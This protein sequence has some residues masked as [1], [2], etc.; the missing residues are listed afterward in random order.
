MAERDTNLT[1]RPASIVTIILSVGMQA[2]RY[3]ESRGPPSYERRIRAVIVINL[4]S[5]RE[6][7]KND[8]GLGRSVVGWF[9]GMPDDQLYQAARG[10]WKL[11]SRADRERHA[12]FVSQGLVRGAVEIKG[13]S[14]YG[15]RRAIEGV[16]DKLLGP[17]DPVYDTYVGKPDPTGSR[18]RNPIRYW[19][20]R[21]V[22]VC[23]CGCGEATEREFLPGHDQRAI[24]ERISRAFRS[25]SEFLV[26]FDGQFPPKQPDPSHN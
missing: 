7:D 16:G 22:N 1:L 24:H 25:V 19:S 21:T 18:T 26:W 8:D 23:G 10:T 2:R 4:A 9:P 20:P 6:V 15:D 13:L 14:V 5:A 12:L 17:G 3:H 11:G